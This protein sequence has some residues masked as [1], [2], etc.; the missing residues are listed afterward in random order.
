MR[1][2]PPPSASD[3]IRRFPARLAAG[4]FLCLIL[5]GCSLLS[6]KVGSD[7]MP[8]RD[9]KLRLQ[10]REFATAFATKVVRTADTVAARSSDP[11]VRAD[12]IRWKLGATA[13]VQQSSLRADPM[14]AL[15]DT[16]VLCRQMK[17]YFTGGAGEP[18]ALGP[19]TPL[20]AQASAQLEQE[21]LEVADTLLSA[22]ELKRASAFV[23]DQCSKHPL[24]SL[25]FE[26]E[27][28]AMPWLK[29]EGPGGA[30]TMGSMSEAITD[31][32]DRVTT[33][34]Q[35]VPNEVRW[36]ID[37]QRQELDLGAG[38]W[39]RFSVG[40]Q[41]ALQSFSTLAENAQLVTKAANDLT[42]T[43]EPEFVRF[44]ERWGTTLEALKTERI[45]VLDTLDSERIAV[46]ESLELQRVALMRDFAR[47]RAEIIAGADRATQS[48]IAQAGQQA[49]AFV[50]TALL[51]GS[52]FA[53]IV[54]GLPFLAGYLVGR[55]IKRNP[56]QASGSGEK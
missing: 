4:V 37:L 24:K 25:A 45:A 17:D 22:R 3:R 47:E 33:V 7:P 51:F 29:Q 38:D 55:A 40:A 26:R 6:V 36:R 23:D 56:P 54:L 30:N 1:L 8:S 35:Q 19:D 2:C 16:W 41:S 52:L 5:C 43:L 46:V 48:A 50:R 53:L 34:G 28:V 15:V 11:K 10:T 13:A 21:I 44:D 20:A 39:K 14:L 32:S 9:L 49:R 31:L 12:T 42:G 27:S 18:A